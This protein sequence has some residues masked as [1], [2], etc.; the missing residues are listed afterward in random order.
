MEFQAI[1]DAEDPDAPVNDKFFED[2][3]AFQVKALAEAGLLSSGTPQ[4]EEGGGSLRSEPP[5]VTRQITHG[6]RIL[7]YP[8]PHRSVEGVSRNDGVGRIT[9]VSAS[10]DPLKSRWGV[11]MEEPYNGT[12]EVGLY[13]FE[14]LPDQPDFGP[15]G[16]LRDARMP[17]P[18]PEA[19]GEAAKEKA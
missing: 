14:I 15:M 4:Q 7:V 3:A 13:D 19:S 9:W 2:Q 18:L 6:T 5:A 12:S 8:G 1:R 10:I 16:N 11:V 17:V